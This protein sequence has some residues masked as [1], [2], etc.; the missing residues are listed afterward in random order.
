MRHA[1]IGSP[2]S[3]SRCETIRFPIGPACNQSPCLLRQFP[4]PPRHCAISTALQRLAGQQGTTE[5][6]R[7]PAVSRSSYAEAMPAGTAL[8][9]AVAR[10]QGAI[11]FSASGSVLGSSPNK[12]LLR[13]C[14]RLKPARNRN[15]P[16]WRQGMLLIGAQY[17]SFL[18]RGVFGPGVCE[19]ALSFPAC[20]LG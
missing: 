13:G 3:W 8:L 2:N 6:P 12:R 1:Q 11:V 9:A 7:Q 16:I 19:D 5:R 15:T 17:Q 4:N 18:R 20:L 10:L 14:Q